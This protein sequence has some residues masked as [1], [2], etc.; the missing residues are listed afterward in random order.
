MGENWSED[1]AGILYPVNSDTAL[2][3]TLQNVINVSI[4]QEIF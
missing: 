4:N 2:F 1:C 3:S